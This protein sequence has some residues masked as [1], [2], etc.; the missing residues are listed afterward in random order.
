LS[1]KP[2]NVTSES[3][4]WYDRSGVQVS[5]V[6]G[7]KGQQVK[8]D[9]RHARKFGF[10]PGV[11]TILKA[12]HKE[13]LVQYRERQVLLASLTL[14]QI[15]GESHDEWVKR[16]M[17]DA[18]THAIEA[19]ERGSEIHAQIESE[20]KTESSTN[21]WV[22]AVRNALS[23]LG[24]SLGA[25]RC[26]MPC[27]SNYGYG[28]KSDLSCDATE[29]DMGSGDVRRLQVVLDFKTK[30][31]DLSDVAL[32]PEHHQ[33][34]AATAQALGLP[35]AQCGIVFV[36]RTEPTACLLMADDEDIQH[37]WQVFKALLNYWQ[38]V[39]KY[40]PEWATNIY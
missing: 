34:L 7:S 24:V 37:G 21:P 8:P 33:Q 3:G 13:Q 30:D 28:T 12:A 31:G 20:L 26:E 32:Y 17:V 2:S 6:L 36:S 11:T 27:V 22:L 19:A 4:H 35:N 16:I 38:T 39:N 10:A 14:P 23:P 40:R 9:L 29:V 1:F 25:W 18:K 5:T 15:A